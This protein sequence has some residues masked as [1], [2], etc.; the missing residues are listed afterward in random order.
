MHVG[1]QTATEYAK[2]KKKRVTREGDVCMSENPL[3]SLHEI[4]GWTLQKLKW[5]HTFSPKSLL[6]WNTA[7]VKGGSEIEDGRGKRQHICLNLTPLLITLRRLHYGAHHCPTS[8]RQSLFH[9][10]NSAPWKDCKNK[11]WMSKAKVNRISPF[12]CQA[13]EVCTNTSLRDREERRALWR[14]ELEKVGASLHEKAK[15]VRSCL[16]DSWAYRKLH[17]QAFGWKTP[18]IHKALLWRQ[19]TRPGVVTYGCQEH[20]DSKML[21]CPREEKIIEQNNIFIKKHA[22]L[23][24][25]DIRCMKTSQS[26]QSFQCPGLKSTL[27]RPKQG[28]NC[29]GQ[30][31]RATSAPSNLQGQRQPVINC[32]VHKCKWVQ[33]GRRGRGKKKG[34][35]ANIPVGSNLLEREMI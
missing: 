29:Q 28:F 4:P 13:G 31:M 24:Q 17:T 25:N 35:Q 16:P 33:W 21:L 19:N 10:A 27:S 12:F 3:C 30:L 32:C 14:K 7:K 8:S 1:G 22:N 26:L 34:C 23:P 6:T 9:C 5:Q 2:K 11:R 15:T 20:R 18:R